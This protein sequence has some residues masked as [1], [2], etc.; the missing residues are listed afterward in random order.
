MPDENA[1]VF[2]SRRGWSLLQRV[3]SRDSYG[4][5]LLLILASISVFVLDT[6]ALSGF[7]TLLRVLVLGD[8]LIFTLYTSAAPRRMYLACAGLLVALVPLSVLIEA[9]SPAGRAIA[10][11]TGLLLTMGTIATI[12][13]RFATRLSVTGSSILAA[14]CVYLLV[15]LAFASIYGLIAAV[16]A[17]GVF[18]GA[19]GDGTNAERIYFSFVTL[20][21]TGYGDFAMATD[22]GRLTAVSEALF[23]Q[24]Y[25]VTIVA[26]LVANIGASRG[27][28][29][30]SQ[31]GDSSE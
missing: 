23:G 12:L 4:F 30:R 25:L 7:A 6:K 18:A 27:R 22:P 2:G 9:S 29:S 1:Q 31:S 26:L 8:M 14:I 17:G 5:L 16:G 20:T 13:R 19:S 24:V 28:A 15:G 3:R 10:A 21:T 11:S